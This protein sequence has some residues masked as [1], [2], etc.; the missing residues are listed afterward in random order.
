MLAIGAV[1][2]NFKLRYDRQWSYVRAIG[3]LS[4]AC[5][6]PLRRWG[7]SRQSPVTEN[8]GYLHHNLA[9]EAAKNSPER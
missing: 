4:P 2:H 1:C 6:S 5:A 9:L 8:L 7:R 3:E